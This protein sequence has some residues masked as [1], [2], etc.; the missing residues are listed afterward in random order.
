MGRWQEDSDLQTLNIGNMVGPIMILSFFLMLGIAL[1]L[2]EIFDVHAKMKDKLLH[3]MGDIAK[4]G[5][6]MGGQLGGKLGALGLKGVH[7]LPGGKEATGGVFT[8]FNSV[9]T[10]T[11]DKLTPSKGSEVGCCSQCSPVQLPFLILQVRAVLRRAFPD[12]ERRRLLEHCSS[13]SLCLSLSRTHSL[14]LSLSAFTT[15][16]QG[17]ER[18]NQRVAAVAGG[19]IARGGALEQASLG[20][21]WRWRWWWEPQGAG[22]SD[23]RERLV[24]R[25]RLGCG[26]HGHRRGAR[27]LLCG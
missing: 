24:E 11:I 1:R 8:M 21:R 9:K 10:H 12:P 22:G 17:P 5:V 26:R 6:G 19:H 2:M 18:Q 16:A 23:A 15:G 14:T 3:P 27:G 20:W 4:L 13:L 25:A 7:T